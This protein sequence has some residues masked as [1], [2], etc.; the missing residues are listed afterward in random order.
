MKKVPTLYRCAGR[1]FTNSTDKQ[2]HL[3]RPLNHLE[4][5]MLPKKK[6]PAILENN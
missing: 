2:R 6:E 1:S 3:L 4:E 5:W